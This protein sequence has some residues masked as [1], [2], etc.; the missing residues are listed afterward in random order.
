MLDSGARGCLKVNNTICSWVNWKPAIEFGNPILECVYGNNTENMPCRSVAKEDVDECND[1][2]SF[3]Q[4]HGV[5]ENATKSSGGLEARLRLHNVVIEKPDPTNLHRG[6]M[7][8][9]DV[10]LVSTPPLA[11]P[12]ANRIIHRPRGRRKKK[13][14]SSSMWGSYEAISPPT[15]L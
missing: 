10:T 12:S 2:E 1:L 9:G 3:S 7:R 15:P 13:C 14:F 11:S 6:K 5:G 8:Q 4:A